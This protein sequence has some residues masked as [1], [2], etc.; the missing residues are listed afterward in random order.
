MGRITSLVVDE[1]HRRERIG[2]A[3]IGVAE[4]WFRTKGCIKFEVTSGNKRLDAH[5]FY[6]KNGYALDGLRFSKVTKE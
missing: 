2:I 5:H 6:E 3:L 4:Q 1:A